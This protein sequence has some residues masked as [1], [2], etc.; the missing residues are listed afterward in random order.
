MKNTAVVI[1]NYNGAGF[2][3][4]FLGN[5]I[6]NSQ[7]ADIYVIDNASTD[8][9]LEMLSNEYKSIKII[10]LDKNYGFAGG[11]NLGL[12]QINNQYLIL[13]NSDV[14]VSKNW[15]EPLVYQLEHSDKIAAVQPHILDQKNKNKYEYAGAAGGHLDYLGFAFCKGRIFDELENYNGQFTDSEPIFWASGACMAVKNSVFKALE[16]FDPRFFAHMEEI[17]LCWRMHNAGYDIVSEPKSVVYHVGGGTLHKS[18]PF[19]TY[20]NYR[21]NLAMLFKNLPASL[22]FPIIFLRLIIDG[23]SSVRYLKS[24]GFADIFA[25]LKAHFAFYAMIPYLWK[26]RKGDFQ[27]GYAKLFKKSIVWKYFALNQKTHKQICGK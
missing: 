2:L 25:I 14:E 27:I 24:G 20:L 15:I 3:K 10:P 7:S 13:L 21:N 22:L 26:L 18:N 16:G 9:S 5:V 17:D 23:V 12:Q 19:K 8:H 11:Y 1:L 6:E 4:Q